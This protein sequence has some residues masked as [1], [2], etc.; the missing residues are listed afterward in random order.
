MT[1]KSEMVTIEGI[2]PVLLE[3]SA[4]AR[5]VTISIRAGK[6]VR[7]A[8][9]VGSSFKTALGFVDKKKDWIKKTL[10][11]IRKIKSGQKFLND[12]FAGIDKE[13]AKEILISRLNALAEKHGFKYNRVYIRNQKTR[14]GSCSHNHNISLNMKIMVLSSE[15][16]DYVLLH[17]LLHTRI[18]NHSK[19]FWSEL[20]KYVPG[21]KAMD[22]RLREYDLRFITV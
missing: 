13:K 12:A 21:A 10:S 4:R 1:T 22:T 2:G 14:W 15:M 3:H 11:R 7:V 9:P 20:D 8:V 19:K 17:E 5:R 6:A 16:R 18:Y